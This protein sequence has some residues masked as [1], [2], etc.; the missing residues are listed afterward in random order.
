MTNFKQ[1]LTLICILHHKCDFICHFY[2]VKVHQLLILYGVL[3]H[4]L[5]HVCGFQ[6]KLLKLNYENVYKYATE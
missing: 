6:K 2:D 1:K 4:R 5:P 3:V